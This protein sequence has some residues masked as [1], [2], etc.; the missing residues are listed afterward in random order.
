MRP[1]L[2]SI[3]AVSILFPSLAYFAGTK[4]YKDM[5]RRQ[6]KQIIWS[7]IPE[8]S[9]LRLSFPTDMD[10]LPG[11]QWMDEGEFRYQ[12]M[13]YDVVRSYQTEDSLILLA[14]A[15]VHEAVFESQLHD[16][17]ARLLGSDPLHADLQ[18]NWSHFL[19]QLYPPAHP[20]ATPVQPGIH[21]ALPS[22]ATSSWSAQFVMNPLT[23]PPRP[24]G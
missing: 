22:E 18:Q 20:P 12:G 10:D 13:M 24:L 9:L 17:M 14:R 21:H 2:A 5:C 11:I 19:K 4:W 7:G 3:L 1:L 15:D 8:E 23:P 16:L 6:A